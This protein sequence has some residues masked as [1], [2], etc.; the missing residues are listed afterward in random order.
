MGSLFGITRQACSQLLIPY[1]KS[2]NQDDRIIEHVKVI[3][4]RMPRIGGLKLHFLLKD[5]F[6]KEG[7]KCGRDKLYL[8]LKRRRML[9]PRRKRFF[10]TTDS[11]HRFNKHSNKLKGLK[12]NKPE[13]AWQSDITYVR[14]KNGMKYLNLITDCAEALSCFCAL[15]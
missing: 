6:K 2:K 15:H 3:R 9:V 11:N 10:R 13:Q 4:K 14:T 7:I 1:H 5:I 12:I 8:L